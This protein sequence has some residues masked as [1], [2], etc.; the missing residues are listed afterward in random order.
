MSSTCSLLTM[1]RGGALD[2]SLASLRACASTARMPFQADSCTILR[3]DT[4]MEFQRQWLEGGH[5]DTPH[6][7]NKTF[8]RTHRVDGTI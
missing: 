7:F 3:K 1:I 6:S 4:I 8:M 5:K 2:V